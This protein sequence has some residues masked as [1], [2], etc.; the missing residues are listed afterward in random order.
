MTKKHFLS[1]ALMLL[2]LA[3]FSSS[4][5]S[6][7]DSDEDIITYYDT[8]IEGYIKDFH[9]GEPVEGVVFD[10]DYISGSGG[11]FSSSPYSAKNIA[12]SNSEGFYKIKIPK[13]RNSADFTEI[14]IHPRKIENY[15][16]EVGIY[17]YQEY[18][19][20]VKSKTIDISP[21]T[22]GYLK[23]ILPKTS[24]DNCG[25]NGYMYSTFEVPY[26]QHELISSGEYSETLKYFFFKVSAS[27]GWVRCG[28]HS[29]TPRFFTI[30]NPRDTVTINIEE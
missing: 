28:N 5:Y 9:T 27:K 25:I 3:V 11:F 13:T 2:L 6:C 14:Q 10:A 7:K 15:N 29:G 16:F 24:S 21:I 4:L 19:F 8:Y 12:V 26:Y 20:S 23:V 30:D 22:Y 18:N 1:K 17:D